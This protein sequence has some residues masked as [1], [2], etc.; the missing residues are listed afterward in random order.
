MIQSPII[1][2]KIPTPVAIRQHG[3]VM[4]HREPGEAKLSMQELEQRIVI[5]FLHL[6][7]EKQPGLDEEGEHSFIAVIERLRNLLGIQ[8]LTTLRDQTISATMKRLRI[9]TPSTGTRRNRT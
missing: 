7:G 3:L 9:E 1:G 2:V 5:P 8:E 4:R 6:I